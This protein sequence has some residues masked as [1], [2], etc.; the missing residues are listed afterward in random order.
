MFKKFSLLVALCLLGLFLFGCGGGG[1]DPASV[2]ESAMNA[3]ITGEVDSLGEYVCA[4]ILPQAEEAAK[5]LK[6]S[7]EEEGGKIE[8]TNMSY[9]VTS[10]EGDKATVE[11]SG[12]VK[13]THPEYG[14]MEEDVTESM[15]VI[16]EDGKW[17]VCNGFL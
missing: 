5:M 8:L 14:D 16:K 1:S 4:D 7:T 12:T 17:K 3:M 9:K 2:V 6:V 10:E 15:D 11:V 13:A